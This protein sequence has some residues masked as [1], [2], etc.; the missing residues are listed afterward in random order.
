[1]GVSIVCALGVAMV[2]ATWPLL[3]RDAHRRLMLA[4]LPLLT[5][6]LALDV[7][8][9]LASTLFATTPTPSTSCSRP[10]SSTWRRCYLA[11]YAAID[12]HRQVAA[13]AGR[14]RSDSLPHIPPGI[15][16]MRVGAGLRDH[17]PSR[18]TSS[19]LGP[20]EALRWRSPPSCS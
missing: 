8:G 18:S 19:S 11:W 9:L 16:G 14:P 10:P 13:R 5:L 7:T 6:G 2:I 12:H 1:V 20:A 3:A 17:R 4:V 15:P